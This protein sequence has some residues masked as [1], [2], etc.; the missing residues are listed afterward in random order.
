MPKLEYSWVTE[1]PITVFT[2]KAANPHIL[3]Y[4][5][6]LLNQIRAYRVGL[7]SPDLFESSESSDSSDIPVD[8]ARVPSLEAANIDNA[9]SMCSSIL[10]SK[11]VAD[12]AFCVY[13]LGFDPVAL[14]MLNP[15]TDELY[16]TKIVTHPGAASAG[17]IM[18]EFAVNYCVQN[19][20]RPYITLWALNET[21]M[22]SYQAIGFE[23][24]SG[25]PQDMYLDLTKPHRKWI[26]L[27]GRW[28]YLSSGTPGLMYAQARMPLPPPPPSKPKSSGP[29]QRPNKKLPPLPPGV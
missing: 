22:P 5:T 11:L 14:M 24:V 18:I 21:S 27:E 19:G 29:R 6:Q 15:L 4:G 9:E 3:R 8:P 23:S 2:G 12:E 10:K 17:S 25:E 1:P 26:C 7:P 16:I 28:R 13:R 20:I